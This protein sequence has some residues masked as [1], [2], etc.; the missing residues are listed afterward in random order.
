MQELVC[1][2]IVGDL[3]GFAVPREFTTAIPDADHTQQDSL[4]ERAREVEV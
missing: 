2:G 3:K 4:G 1:V